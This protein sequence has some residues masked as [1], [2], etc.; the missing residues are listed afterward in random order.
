MPIQKRNRL[1]SSSKLLHS[2]LS[3]CLRSQTIRRSSNPPKRISHSSFNASFFVFLRSIHGFRFSV[4]VILSSKFVSEPHSRS[5]LARFAAHSFV[6]SAFMERVAA[7][8]VPPYNGEEFPYSESVWFPRNRE[9]KKGKTEELK[10]NATIIFSEKK[11]C[12]S[13]LLA[14][15]WH[16]MVLLLAV[17]LPV[18]EMFFNRYGAMITFNGDVHSDLSFSFPLNINFTP[19]NAFI[20]VPLLLLWLST[21]RSLFCS[22]LPLFSKPPLLSICA[23]KPLKMMTMKI[24]T[25]LR[26]SM[27]QPHH[28]MTQDNYPDVD[29][30]VAVI[31]DDDFSSFNPLAMEVYKEFAVDN[32]D[33]A[34]KEPTT[35]FKV[36]DVVLKLGVWT[37]SSTM[38]NTQVDTIPINL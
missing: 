38:I 31:D 36:D 22:H 8:S 1:T 10:G 12:F 29:H 14:S 6:D 5:N 16:H 20:Y 30:F 27:T 26:N 19:S 32:K 13:L 15:S 28:T 18:L 35:K 21:E 2:F 9:K 11:T 7:I 33:V 25:S 24:S 37:N 34:L 17:H 3:L 4:S 23:R